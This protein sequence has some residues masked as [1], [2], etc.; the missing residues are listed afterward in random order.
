MFLVGTKDVVGE[1]VGEAPSV[2]PT[3]GW[4]LD[5]PL[6]TPEGIAVGIDDGLTLGC[7]DGWSLGCVDG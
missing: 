6:G 5:N 4:S 1:N 3:V 7:A 2:V